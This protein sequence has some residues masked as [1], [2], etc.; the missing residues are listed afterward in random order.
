M[1]TNTLGAVLAGIN[2]GVSNGLDIYKTIQNEARQKR[3]EEYQIKRD[4]LS[5]ARYETER[6]YQIDRDQLGDQRYEKEWDYKVEQDKAAAEAAAAKAQRED[7][8][9][10][11]NYMLNA[12]RLQ[13][14]TRGNDLKAMKL[15]SEQVTA[16][17]TDIGTMMDGTPEG[18]GRAINMMNTSPAH[19]AAGIQ[20]AR[21]SGFD[22]P[23]DVAGR[24]TIV[25][26][27]KGVTFAVS[28]ADGNM[29]PYDPDGDG[30]ESAFQMD[31]ELFGSLLGGVKGADAGKSVRALSQAQGQ[32]AR[33]A[34]QDDV[35]TRAAADH[36]AGEAEQELATAKS[37]LS[38][39]QSAP[40]RTEPAPAP[41][42]APVYVTSGMQRGMQ[43]NP[44]DPQAASRPADSRSGLQQPRGIPAGETAKH[45]ASVSLAQAGVGAAEARL[46]TAQNR[47]ADSQDAVPQREQQRA[48][49][50]EK[51]SALVNSKKMGP[52]AYTNFN[53]TFDANPFLANR[54]PG[55]S[56]QEATGEWDKE[57]STF[58]KDVTGSLDVKTMSSPDN[59]PPRNLMG[60]K[61][62]VEAVLYSMPGEMQLAIMDHTRTAKGALKHAA[63]QALK[64]GKPEAV[65]YMLYA[66]KLNIDGSKA[67]EL[68][69]DEG[70]ADIEDQDVRFSVAADAI[71]LVRSG[72][73]KDM[74]A[75]LLRAK[76]AYQK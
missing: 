39:A 43:I 73:V 38:A 71:Q 51:V 45:A 3:A 5:D 15:A 58:I 7:F 19:H 13:Q 34:M 8:W 6:K 54:Y 63:Q 75:A 14:Q 25:P 70:L 11:A 68:M 59:K 1:S 10:Q 40:V 31:Y 37:T 23:D 26:T 47:V 29:T 2:N 72:E 4:T 61:S 28:D 24:L 33:Q 27:G 55:K 36:A 62:D 50:I 56:L 66:D 46:K 69:Q 52:E 48:I 60:A 65:P 17:R 22:I 44:P 53:Q 64:I 49:G 9:K 18:W 30:P 57:L 16:A 32:A 21:N 42:P 76:Q 67:M 12:G 74:D 41:A 35:A 20:L